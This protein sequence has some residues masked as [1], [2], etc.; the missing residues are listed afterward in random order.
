MPSD[1]GYA[2]ARRVDSTQAVAPSAAALDAWAWTIVRVT[3]GALLIPHGWGKLSGDMTMVAQGFAAAGIA[4]ALLAAWYIACLEFFGGILLVL[5]LLTR[6]VAVLVVGFMAVAA[7]Y[8]HWP[9]GFL[10][11]N[12]GF[13]YPL[14]WGLMALALVLRGG[15]PWSLDRKIGWKW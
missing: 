8:V 12:K 14:M 4:P 7:F 1:A 13:E 15:G 5:G 6:P 9:N 11:T 10:W 3:V 2:Q